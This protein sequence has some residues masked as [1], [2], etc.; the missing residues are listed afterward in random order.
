MISLDGASDE[1]YRV[2]RQGGHFDHVVSNVARLAAAKKRL[3]LSRPTLTWKFVIFD[4]NRHEV[5]QVKK[6]YRELGF[7]RYELVQDSYSNRAVDTRN[8]FYTNMRVNQ[9]PCYWLWNT[10]VLLCDGTVNPCCSTQVIKLGNAVTEN[11]AEIW[12]GRNYQALRRGFS[13]RDFG[14]RMIPRCRRCIG[15]DAPKESS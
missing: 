12:R 8:D 3:G 15:L 1:T 10:M 4:H 2:Y 13:R 5:S 7:D 14:E 9:K 11:T 6:T